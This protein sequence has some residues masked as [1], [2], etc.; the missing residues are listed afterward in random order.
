MKNVVVFPKKYSC[1]RLG[2]IPY[3]Q[4]VEHLNKLGS[5]PQANIFVT[6]SNGTELEK[7]DA[8][9]LENLFLKGPYPPIHKRFKRNIWF[10]APWIAG[11]ISKLLLGVMESLGKLQSPGHHLFVGIITLYP[12]VERYG[13]C[14]SNGFAKRCKDRGFE[15]LG[16]DKE[17][18]NKVLC[19]GYKHKTYTEPKSDLLRHHATLVFRKINA[20]LKLV[21]YRMLPLLYD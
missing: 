8:T 21:S 14:L 1:I 9:K 17:F 11:S 2:F 3:D 13:I 7:V 16:I 5:Q 6:T 10:Q 18:I 19:L 20:P 15:Y 4:A 12:L